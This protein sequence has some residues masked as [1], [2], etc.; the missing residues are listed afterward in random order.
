MTGTN[1]VIHPAYP[2]RAAVLDGIAAARESLAD[3]DTALALIRDGLTRG[4]IPEA[5][6]ARLFVEAMQAVGR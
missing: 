1:L 4:V 6:A 5:E 2:T 3:H